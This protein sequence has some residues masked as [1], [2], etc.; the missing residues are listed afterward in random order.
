LK[1]QV[2]KSATVYSSFNTVIDENDVEVDQHAESEFGKPEVRR[3]L[4]FLNRQRFFPP[5]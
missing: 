3:K 2:A 5:P 4:V 1:R